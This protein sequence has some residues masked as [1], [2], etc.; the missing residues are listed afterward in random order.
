M[1]ITAKHKLKDI[2]KI[3]PLLAVSGQ[4]LLK[5]CSKFDM[6]KTIQ[7]IEPMKHSKI[8]ILQQSAIW[9]IKD[10]AEL[11]NAYAEIFFGITKKHT[12]WLA[13]CPIIDFY[14]FAFEVQQQSIRYAEEL[15]NIKVEL[16]EAEKKAGYGE[17]DPNGLLNLVYAMAN[18][19]HVSMEVAWNYPLVEYIF[20]FQNDAKESN[21]QRKYNKIISETK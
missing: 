15:S 18:K 13:N 4:D 11:L 8:T 6:P 21:R 20:T 3:L 12:T 5:E 17:K 2:P 10:N 16:T 7:G 14:R 1:I 19:K 9:D